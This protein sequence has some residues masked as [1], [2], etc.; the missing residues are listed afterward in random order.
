MEPERKIEKW[1]RAFAKKRREQASQ[2]LELRPATRQRLQREIARQSEQ[3]NRSGFFSNFFL[4]LRLK[5][6][7]A[8][9]ALGALVLWPPLI[10]H[11]PTSLSMNKTY[12]PQTPPVS[13]T[14]P[15]MAPPPAMSPLPSLDLKTR[16]EEQPVPAAPPSTQPTIASANRT[17]TVEPSDL[18][19][20][21]DRAQNVV[22]QKQAAYTQTAPP[23]P[24]TNV[25]F[26]PKDETAG[27]SAAAGAASTD[28]QGTLQPGSMPQGSNLA[29]GSST[30]AADQQ[31]SE[32]KLA[33]QTPP[34]ATANT[35]LLKR[36]M[37]TTNAAS[38]LT[39]SQMFARVGVSSARRSETIAAAPSLS[40]LT[41]F[42]VEQNGSSM[43]VVDADGSLN[44]GSV[45]I[46]PHEP[47]GAAVASAAPN[48]T[49]A[50]R[51]LRTPAAAPQ[52]YF[53][54]V[55]GTNRNLNENVVFS[56]NFVPITNSQLATGNTRAFGGV[57]SN[58][59]GGG[60]G[61]AAGQPVEALLSNSRINGAVVI[62]NQK[63]I[64][65][66]ATPSP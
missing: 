46:A 62:G 26:A 10:H 61:R 42:R 59:N 16:E 19:K 37:T 7:F 27:H 48:N 20:Q 44:S 45:Q 60:G 28:A 40:V 33:M 2:P 53:F 47:P 1:L 51:L 8:A 65:V 5:V 29:A 9:L 30:F 24:A 17:R 32:T 22:A 25:Y 57:R 13:A 14:E 3:K 63:A 11:R 34:V 38:T 36:A 18:P 52:T 56:G 50:S 54:R 39:A 41:S 6:V 66:I 4:G 55:A 58:G 49:P 23:T 21:L 64:D 43:K 35:E 15:E 12:L 31:R